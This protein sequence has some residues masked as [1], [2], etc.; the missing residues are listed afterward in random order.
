MATIQNPSLYIS[1][2]LEV[3]GSELKTVKIADLPNKEIIP[4][5]RDTMKPIVP[6]EGC[7]VKNNTNMSFS[8][9]KGVIGSLKREFHGQ[10]RWYYKT[11]VLEAQ[12]EYIDGKK[13]GVTNEYFQEGGISAV[14]KYNKGLLDGEATFYHHNGKLKG[15]TEWKYGFRHGM[16][17]KFDE[18]D[19]L[20]S[21]NFYLDGRK[22]SR[23]DM[24]NWLE[25][26]ST[27]HKETKL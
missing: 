1:P 11:G 6:P 7:I 10:V 12:C 27:Q 5:T 19:R 21:E 9:K 25:I 23:E 3:K 20:Y 17:R 4:L 26:Q 13:N 14:V 18:N 15:I 16:S 2:I 22:Q 24:K 8:I